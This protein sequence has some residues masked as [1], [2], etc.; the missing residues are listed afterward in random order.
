MGSVTNQKLKN[1]KLSF[2][3]TK[4]YNYTLKDNKLYGGFNKDYL[5]TNKEVS[6]I[7]KT[8]NLDIYYISNDTLYY[9][10]PLIW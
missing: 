9:F 6:K 2:E 5:V 3:E 1:N 7:I 10:N 8:D 4:I